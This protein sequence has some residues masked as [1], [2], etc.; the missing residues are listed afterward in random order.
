M[1]RLAPL[2]KL[3]QLQRLI[4]VM[5]LEKR[6]WSLTCR[7]FRR[8]VKRLYWGAEAA[9]AVATVDL[10][11]ALRRLEERGLIE[12]FTHGGWRLTCPENDFV[13]NGDMH[14][15]LAWQNGAR[16]YVKAGLRGP[17]PPNSVLAG[18]VT[19]QRKGVEVELRF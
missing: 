8:V 19:E 3:S 1:K 12:R 14:A 15:L 17:H 13:R 10:C 2:N 6:L 11:R 9:S 4:L 18:P 16:M 7:E 5:L